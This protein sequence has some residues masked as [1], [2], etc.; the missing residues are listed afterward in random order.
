MHRLRRCPRYRSAQLV[1][2]AVAYAVDRDYRERKVARSSARHA[3]LRGEIQPS[4]CR[5]GNPNAQ[6]HHPDYS[7]PL[8]VV[9]LCTGCHRLEHHGPDL[10]STDAGDPIAELLSRFDARR[11]LWRT[12]PQ[13]PV[14]WQ[15]QVVGRVA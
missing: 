6:M 7:K 14:E 9:W 3:L 13:S 15:L 1:Q 8:E 10:R 4:A 2:Q 5:C 12:T 11:R